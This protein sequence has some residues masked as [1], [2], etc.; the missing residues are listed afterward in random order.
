MAVH[1]CS[2]ITEGMLGLF[3]VVEYVVN[4]ARFLTLYLECLEELGCM[5]EKYGLNI[6]QPSPKEALKEIAKQ[7][8]DRDNSVRSA[9]LNTI[10]VAYQILGDQVYKYVGRVSLYNLHVGYSAFCMVLSMEPRLLFHCSH[11]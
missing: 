6:C 3:S 11:H 9:A 4:I 2:K 7:I 1:T 8:A 10:V 5:M